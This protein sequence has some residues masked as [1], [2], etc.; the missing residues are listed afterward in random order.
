MANKMF[1][2]SKIPI[3]PLMIF[4]LTSGCDYQRDRRNSMGW[5]V[6]VSEKEIAGFLW[7]AQ[8]AV[9]KKNVSECILDNRPENTLLATFLTVRSEDIIEYGIPPYTHKDGVIEA[10]F[11]VKDNARMQINVEFY[12][13][14]KKCK[15]YKIN[16]VLI[17]G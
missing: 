12:I 1:F 3:L 16:S 6:P 5:I 14:G 15:K 2:L 11:R 9:T 17:D 13:E 8:A 7:S 4:F 10:F